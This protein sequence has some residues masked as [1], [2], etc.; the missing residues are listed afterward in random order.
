MAGSLSWRHTSD[1]LRLD[2][3][4]Q[5]M[6]YREM[7]SINRRNDISGECHLLAVADELYKS[8]CALS[9]NREIGIKTNNAM[10]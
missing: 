9:I 10:K 8:I 4:K 3:F 1:A 2:E 6:K 7:H 5:R